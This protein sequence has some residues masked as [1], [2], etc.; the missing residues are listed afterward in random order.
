MLAYVGWGLASA[1]WVMY[2]VIVANLLGNTVAASI[3]SIV[4][5]AA[6]A[7]DQGRTMGAISSLNSLMAVVAPPFG[8]G[9]LM[10]VSHLSPGDWRLG[11]PMFFCAALQALALSMAWRHFARSRRAPGAEPKPVA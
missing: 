1:G 9:L 2:V 11:L 4:S 10:L 7:R 8:A 3:N 6:D 5:G